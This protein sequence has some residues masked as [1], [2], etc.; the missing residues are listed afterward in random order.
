MSSVSCL[1][2]LLAECLENRHNGMLSGKAVSQF[3]RP[4]PSVKVDCRV[5]VLGRGQESSGPTSCGDL[6][7]VAI[8]VYLLD[9]Y[10][11]NP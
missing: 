4:Q 6:V 9:C 11:L 10:D 5:S 1:G 7:V 8:S 2:I 3:V